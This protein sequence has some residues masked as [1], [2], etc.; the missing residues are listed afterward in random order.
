[1]KQ[2]FYFLLF[3]LCFSFIAC[4][5]EDDEPE[6]PIVGDIVF[7]LD[8]DWGCGPITVQLE[9]AATKTL[10]S[11]FETGAPDC[12]GGQNSYR[13]LSYGTYNWTARANRDCYWEGSINL[14]QDCLRVVLSDSQFSNKCTFIENESC[15][16]VEVETIAESSN[17]AGGLGGVLNPE[18]IFKITN[19]CTT[20][21]L[22]NLCYETNI[23]TTRSIESVVGASQTVELAACADTAIYT[24][25]SIDN[26]DYTSFNCAD[27]GFSCN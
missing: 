27:L 12:D 25:W 22:V 15:L 8:R 26:D 9:S 21:R 6:G 14:N 7:Y 2:L 16:T 17:C 20:D 23:G 13:N 18:Q 4:S 1:M 24:L 10:D 19:N 11:F 5:S 3:S